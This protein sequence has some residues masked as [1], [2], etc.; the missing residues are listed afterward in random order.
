[1]NERLDLARRLGYHSRFLR[2][3]ARSSG[4]V[5][6][7]WNLADLK[8]SLQFISEHGAGAHST[9]A[10]AAAAIFLRTEDSD[11]RR[12][13]L[14]GLSRMTNPRARTELLRLSQL[15]DL[16]QGGKDLIISY[17]NAPVPTATPI[18]STNQKPIS[19]RVDQ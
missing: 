2:E 3:V 18:A 7:A 16:D 17:L 8:R 11:T 10:K 5:D 15:R 4:E 6:V 19:N 12:F 1:M 9:T 13:C 14:D